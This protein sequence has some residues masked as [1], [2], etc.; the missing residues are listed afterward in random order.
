VLVYLKEPMAYS[1]MNGRRIYGEFY[2]Y[3]SFGPSSVSRKF[4]F[5]NRDR[6]KEV[7]ITSEWLVS[8]TGEL[9]PDVSFLTTEMSKLDFEVIVAIARGLGIKYIEKKKITTEEKKALNRAI[10]YHIEKLQ[11]V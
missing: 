5:E 8:Q 9:F 6:L 2:S 4:F 3:G 10:V 11:G 1:T 7:E